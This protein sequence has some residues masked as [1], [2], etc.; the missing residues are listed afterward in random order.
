VAWI[1]DQ[2]RD[3]EQSAQQCIDCWR[4]TSAKSKGETV[5][6]LSQQITQW[7]AIA[8][9]S[10]VITPVLLLILVIE[11]F[12]FISYLCKIADALEILLAIFA[13]ERPTTKQKQTDRK[14]ENTCHTVTSN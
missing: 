7:V 14:R 1:P 2:T 10:Y 8:E 3:I 9:V 4:L 11:A 13:D 6:A 5:D 12:V